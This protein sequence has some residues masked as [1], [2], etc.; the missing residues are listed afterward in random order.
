MQDLALAIRLLRKSPAF[1]LLALLCLALGIG[2]NASIF[3]LLDSVYLRP[4]PVGN[5][6]RVVVFSRGGS[7]LFSYR[8]YRALRDRNQSLDGLAISQPEESD[9]S[10]EGSAMLTGAEPVSANYAAVLGAHTILGRWFTREDEPAAVIGYHA[11]QQLFHG[12]PSVLGK[13][14]RSESNTYT[15][16]GVAPPGFAGIYAPLRI[17]LWVPFHYWAGDAADNHRGMLFGCLKRG[18]G[19]SRA[20]AELNAAAALIHRENPDMPGDA[21]APLLLEPVRGIP[22]PVMRRQAMPV[23]SLLMAV[24]VLVLLI[25][26]MNVGNLLVARGMGRQREI[27]VRFALGGC[28]ARVLRQL[29]TENLA[30]GILGGAAGVLVGYVSNRLLVAALPVL[31]FGEMIRM[32]LPLDFRVLLYTGSVALLTALLFGLLPALQS[33]RGELAAVLKGTNIAGGRLRLRLAMLTGQIALSLVLLLTAGLFARLIVRFHNLDPGFASANRLYAPAFVPAPQFTPVSGRVFYDQMLARLRALPGVRNAALTTRLP[34]YAAGI[35]GTCVAHEGDRPTPATSTTIDRG[36]LDTLRI[37]ILEGRDFASTDKAGRAPVAIVNQTL[38]RRLWLNQPAVGRT[39]QV[40]CDHPRSLQVVGVARDSKIRSMNEVTLPHVYLPFSQA[41]E[42]GIVFLVVETVGDSGPLVERVRRTLVSA[43][44]DFRTCGVQ[45]LSDSLD[46]SFWQARF[47]LWVLG[48]LG[49]LALVLAAVGMYGVLAYHVTARTR[50]IGIRMAL[51]ARPRE[52]V[53]LVIAQGLRVTIAGIAIGLIISAVA[54]RL[55]T[56]LLQGVSPTDAATWSSA[57]GVWI[58]VALVAC[59]L[60]A[61]RATRVA[62]VVALR[63]E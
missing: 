27:A 63:E 32:D 38:A 8:E 40:G 30:L 10:F 61:R 15:V 51:G 50:E 41:Y 16:V 56:T 55:L 13:T 44:P 35:A 33:S 47:E 6:N 34:M 19:V 25:A 54:A 39:L 24:V 22:S 2:V 20:A 43:D 59:W 1:T 45:R 36:F 53:Q 26:C 17:D 31:P 37:P 21:R 14:I 52:V 60:P 46:A 48:I 62:P 5:A 58:A 9:L 28:R 42:G 11:W 57:V 18:V 7:P 3:S 23:V 4:L 49:A 29:M 12:D